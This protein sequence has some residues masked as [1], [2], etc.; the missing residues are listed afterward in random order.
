LLN[1]LTSGEQKTSDSLFTTLDPV[2]RIISITSHIK[3]ILSDTVGFLS[4]LPH[5][6]IEAFKATLEELQYADILIHVIDASAQNY[7]RLIAAVD[8]ILKELGLDQ[9]P[10]VLVFNKIDRLQP[11]ELEKIKS[12]YPDSVFLSAL[13]KSNLDMITERIKMF[14]VQDERQIVVR[15]PFSDMGVLDYLYK[16]SHVFKVEYS[17]AEVIVWFSIKMTF[18]PYLEKKGIEIKEV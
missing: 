5:N 17:P 14:L 11:A 15:F 9:K 10:I 1:S 12:V 3:V 4:N 18:L 2:S 13:K 7:P 16:N 6:L 8:L